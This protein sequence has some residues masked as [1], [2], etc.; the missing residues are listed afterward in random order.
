MYYRLGLMPT[1]IAD[2]VTTQYTKS[3]SAKPV[4][5]HRPFVALFRNRRQSGIA[6]VRNWR[7]KADIDYCLPIHQR[8]FATT[9]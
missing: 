4:T 9:D 5:D 8:S 6:G 7:S 2:L 1:M 3:N